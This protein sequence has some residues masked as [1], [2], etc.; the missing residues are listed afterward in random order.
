MNIYEQET[1]VGDDFQ[2]TYYGEIIKTKMVLVFINNSISY[3]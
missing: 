1:T 2:L 3:L